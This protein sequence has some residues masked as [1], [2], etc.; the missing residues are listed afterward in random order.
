MKAAKKSL[1]YAQKMLPNMS[2]S[3]LHPTFPFQVAEMKSMF[4]TPLQ[5]LGLPE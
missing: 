3:K 4:F 5:K 2:C 1:E